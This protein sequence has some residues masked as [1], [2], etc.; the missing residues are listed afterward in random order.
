MSLTR[1]QV[2]KTLKRKVGSIARLANDLN[3]T[4]ATV[5]LVLRGRGT[6][7]RVMAAATVRAIEILR[8]EAN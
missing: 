8:S 3:L 5:S 1:A 7:A 6:S 4:P 2:R